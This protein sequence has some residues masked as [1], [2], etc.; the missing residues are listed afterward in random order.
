MRIRKRQFR[1]V[2][3]I[4]VTHQK[5]QRVDLTETRGIIFDRAERFVVNTPGGQVEIHH[6]DW[7]IE[8]PDDR[9][10]VIKDIHMSSFNNRRRKWWHLW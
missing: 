3:F 5:A 1:G 7:V 4:G 8:F 2:A 6:G 9:F 10:Y